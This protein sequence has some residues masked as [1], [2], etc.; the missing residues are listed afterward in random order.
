MHEYE[1]EM[2]SKLLS[3]SELNQ[4]ERALL[5]RLN[6]KQP[7]LDIC[8]QIYFVNWHLRTLE[9]KDDFSTLGISFDDLE[10]YYDDDFTRCDIPYNKKTHQLVEDF[11]P[12]LTELPADTIIVS[13]PT[14]NE[15]DVVGS[16]RAGEGYLE[17]RLEETPQ[18][19]HFEAKELTG[20]KSWLVNNINSNRKERGL[21][22]LR[23]SGRSRGKGI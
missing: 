9:R 2:R 22:P 11:D 10:P 21:P 6:G 1:R 12:D 4:N 20:K 13:F 15:M 7:T 23:R 8:G 14:P 18:R 3:K 19:S 5:D 17:D 16:V